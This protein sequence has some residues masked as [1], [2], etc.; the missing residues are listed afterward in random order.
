[1]RI[2]TEAR[3]INLAD[4]RTGPARNLT[5]GEQGTEERRVHYRWLNPPDSS[6]VIDT[7]TGAC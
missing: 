1:M 4:R 2:D 7:V 6:F 5:A 3:G